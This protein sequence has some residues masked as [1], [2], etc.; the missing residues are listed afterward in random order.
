VTAFSATAARVGGLTLY[1]SAGAASALVTGMPVLVG[2]VWLLVVPVSA[3]LCFWPR[4]RGVAL[5]EPGKPEAH[6]VAYREARHPIPE[7]GD[8][9]TTGVQLIPLARRAKGVA[10]DLNN[11]LGVMRASLEVL[12]ERLPAADPLRA[13]TCAL[14]DT[15]SRAS[16]LAR[17]LV[18]N[19]VSEP[20]TAKSFDLLLAARAIQPLL[21]RMLPPGVR[22]HFQGDAASWVVAGQ[23]EVEQLIVNLVANARDAIGPSGEIWIDLSSKWLDRTELPAEGRLRPGCYAVLRVRD[24]GSG[25]PSDVLPH[26]FDPFFTTKPVGSGTGLGLA[27]S[28]DLIC[29]AGGDVMVASRPGHGTCFKVLL[30]EQGVPATHESV[31]TATHALRQVAGPGTPA[32]GIKVWAS[33]P[34][35]GTFEQ[36]RS[37]L[38]VDD[39]P[40]LLRSTSRA[41]KRVGHHVLTACDAEVALDLVRANPEHIGTL[42]TD[43][44]LPGMSGPDLA[45]ALRNQCRDLAIVFITGASD[46]KDL[47]LDDP[48]TVVVQKPFRADEL[49][50]AVRTARSLIPRVA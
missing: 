48:S 17:R 40:E 36:E 25:I 30:P 19:Q 34:S 35:S 24:T 20:S 49:A 14:S 22:R 44:H 9:D 28:R 41:L 38:V 1:A 4:G 13:E 42:V 45:R 8:S 15:V 31:P 27:A 18:D 2:V 33:E 46:M 21:A 39:H 43:V 29:K 6:T 26:I 10:H 50:S 32:G 3:L 23:T 37:V 16:E 12:D 5:P 11:L 47:G 7:P